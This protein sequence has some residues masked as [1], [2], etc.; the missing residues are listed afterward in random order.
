VPTYSAVRCAG[1]YPGIDAVYYGR[2]TEL[3]YDFVVAAGADPGAIRLAFENG[4]KARLDDRGDLLLECGGAEV[5]HCRPVVYQEQAGQRTPVSASYELQRDAGESAPQVAFRV[6]AYDRSRP[7]IIDPVLIYSTYF[8]G[9]GVELSRGAG[10][11]LGEGG[12]AYVVGDTDSNALPGAG[13][14]GA[15]GLRDAFVTKLN[16]TGTAVLFTTYLGGSDSDVAHG[17]AVDSQGNLYVAGETFSRDFPVAKAIQ[18]NYGGIA[19]SDAFLTKL[20]PTGA[21]LLFSTYLGGSTGSDAAEAVALDAS[22]NPWIAGATNST[23]FPVSTPLQPT[24][25]GGYDA[26]VAGVSASGNRILASTYLG[27]NGDDRARGIAIGAGDSVS[28][29]GGTASSNFPL[30]HPVQATRGFSQD[31]FVAQLAAGGTSLIFSTYLGGDGTDVATGIAAAGDS[32]AVTG[33]TG[34]LNFPVSHAYQPRPGGRGD[35]F[36]ARL[37]PPSGEL[38]YSTYLGG[39]G[40]ENQAFAEVGAIALDAE[41][42]ALIT[43]LTASR[44]FPLAGASQ[45][46]PGGRA[47]AFVARLSAEGGSLLYSTYLG[48][49]G[50]DAGEA[51]AVDLAGNAYV[52]GQ[53][54]SKNLPLRNPAQRTTAG[55]GDAFIAK[56]G[57]VSADTTPVLVLS[58]KEID[59][60]T[61][62]ARGGFF[63]LRLTNG[64]R[65]KLLCLVTD[66]ESP[67][68]VLVGGGQF[69]V[70]RGKSRTLYLQFKPTSPGDYQ[71][72]LVI[73]TNDPY[74]PTAEIHLHGATSEP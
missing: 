17:V 31:A 33:F 50:D 34:S 12:T 15:G 72:T 44:N 63:K 71:S 40:T 4:R 7:L 29:C 74:F 60:G 46:K 52:T 41:G 59:F 53:T 30:Q 42:S 28:V 43:G 3:E 32:V 73:D 23:N 26:F 38:T 5:R 9:G 56:V 69:T 70:G 35:A 10:I 58:D 19:F 68:K 24:P 67:F 21:T 47:D 55:G 27:G 54:N 57:N 66:P 37:A 48:G 51:I 64:G 18:P 61:V 16:A 45:K 39:S 1:V 2:G 20:D 25:G 6:G 22:G 62:N 13:F 8:G 36:V 11:A 49:K 14:V 65:G